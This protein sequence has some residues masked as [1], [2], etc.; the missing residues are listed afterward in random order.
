MK[1]WKLIIFFAL[2]SLLAACGGGD[3]AGNGEEAVAPQVEVVESYI[4]AKTAAD[5]DTLQRYICADMEAVLDAE[6]MSFSGIETSIEEMAC[7]YEEDL[8]EVV[9][10]GAIIAVYD[11]ENTEFPL[12]RYRVV[13]EDGEWKWCGQTG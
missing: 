4:R 12:G 11:G 10:E 3:D 9:C 7:T 6:A 2:M 8:G 13:E 5:R 1:L